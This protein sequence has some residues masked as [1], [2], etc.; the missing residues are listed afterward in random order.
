MSHLVADGLWNSWCSIYILYPSMLKQQENDLCS[1]LKQLSEAIR[2]SHLS[3]G[4]AN[5]YQFMA[6]KF[7]D[8]INKDCPDGSRG[9]MG[10]ALYLFGK[11][12][13]QYGKGCLF[14]ESKRECGWVYHVWKWSSSWFITGLKLQFW[15]A[16]PCCIFFVTGH[17]GRVKML[18][19]PMATAEI[20]HNSHDVTRYD[21]KLYI[22]WCKW[23][24]DTR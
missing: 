20:F 11:E 18:N 24:L 21:I 17:T 14:P 7:P 6:W 13:P 12:R 4:I 8:K 10:S 16:L 2:Q 9:W 5:I 23:W 22:F 1:N 19:T 3:P 15:G